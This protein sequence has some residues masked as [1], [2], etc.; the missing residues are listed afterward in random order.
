MLHRYSTGV[1]LPNENDYWN[2]TTANPFP[3]AFN[4]NSGINLPRTRV[5]PGEEPVSLH[6]QE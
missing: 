5:C 1:S 6:N 4:T 3:Q 2:E